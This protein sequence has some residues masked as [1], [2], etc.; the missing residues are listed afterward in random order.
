MGATSQQGEDTQARLLKAACKVFSEKGYHL[1]KIA[2][3]C[4]LAG[5]NIAAVNYYFRS[6]ENLYVQAWRDAFNRSIAAYP[7]DGGVDPGAPPE[8]RLRGK[9]LSL[10]RRIA[11]PDNQEFEIVQKEL[12]QP[13]GILAEVIRDTL[14]PIRSDTEKLVRELLGSGASEEDVALCEMSIIAQCL[15][16]LAHQRHLKALSRVKPD[17]EYPLLA[18]DVERMADHVFRFSLAGIREIR[19][20][21]ENRP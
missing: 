18:L 16:P 3:I 10:M 17:A 4:E 11:D 15:Q 5:T 2:E 1:A 7:P 20:R 6:K 21:I 19:R 9:I 13:T 12:A 14:E 8:E